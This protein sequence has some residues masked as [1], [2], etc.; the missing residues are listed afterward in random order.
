M[1]VPTG[2]PSDGVSF[3]VEQDAVDEA[4]EPPF[5]AACNKAACR[6]PWPA[7]RPL[8]PSRDTRWR[9]RPGREDPDHC[10]RVGSPS[11][12]AARPRPPITRPELTTSRCPNRLTNRIDLPLESPQ[13][14]ALKSGSCLGGPGRGPPLAASANFLHRRSPWGSRVGARR[15]PPRDSVTEGLRLSVDAAQLC[16]GPSFMR[17]ASVGS[18]D[19]VARRSLDRAF[20]AFCVVTE[21]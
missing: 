4:G 3:A 16:S 10:S 1:D 18:S 11:A 13:G 12:V 7:R 5:G 19:P 17:F 15:S 8:R 6:R 14:A 21:G 20:T 2:S 9:R